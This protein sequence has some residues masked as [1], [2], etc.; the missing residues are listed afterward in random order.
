MGSKIW[1]ASA[2][3]TENQLL[4]TYLIRKVVRNSTYSDFLLEYWSIKPQY[5]NGKKKLPQNRKNRTNFAVSKPHF[6]GCGFETAKCA[7]SKPQQNHA[8]LWFWNRMR[9]QSLDLESGFA[10]GS[11][12]RRSSSPS[13]CRCLTF[14]S[15]M[16]TKSPLH[17]VLDRGRGNVLTT[18]CWS[19]QK[20]EYLELRLLVE[21]WLLNHIFHE[22]RVVFIKHAACRRHVSY[23][24]IC[25]TYSMQYIQ[26]A[27]TACTL[28]LCSK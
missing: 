4:T 23:I 19:T 1:C 12:C 10:Y 21:I 26:H 18:Q 25:C 6:L 7:V 27:C 15:L 20:L 22:C 24:A 11:R 13:Q 16:D 3:P 9:F 8:V 5:R 14:K 28:S 2:P 17:D